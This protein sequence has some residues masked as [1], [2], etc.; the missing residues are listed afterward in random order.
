VVVLHVIMQCGGG[1]C[2]RGRVSARD[3]GNKKAASVGGYL[4]RYGLWLTEP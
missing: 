1:I 2:Q 3:A 4:S